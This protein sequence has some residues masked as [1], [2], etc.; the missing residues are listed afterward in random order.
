QDIPFEKLVEVLQPERTLQH[1]ALFQVGFVLQNALT[2]TFELPDLTLSSV[3]PDVMTAIIDLKLSVSDGGPSLCAQIEYNADLFAPETIVRLLGQWRELLKAVVAAPA[4]RLSELPLMSAEEERELAAWNATAGGYELNACLHE[5]VEQQAALTPKRI[6]V[7]FE[8]DTISYEELNRRGNQL[9]RRL[10][11]LGVGP[12]TK[13]GVLLERSVELVVGL[14][15]IL[16]AGG[17]YVPLDP[18]YPAERLQFMIA[19]SGAT[20]LLTQTRFEEL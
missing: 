20:V 8:A 14:L 6:A 18:Q 2:K 16:K 10:R 7:G 1:Q 13:V 19:D 4:T 9:A 11:G 17:A 15:G 12:E 5:L 3:E